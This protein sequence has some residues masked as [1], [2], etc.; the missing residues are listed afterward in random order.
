LTIEGAT[1]EIDFVGGGLDSG[2]IRVVGNIGSFAARL[3]TGGKIE[4]R[5]NVGDYL[6]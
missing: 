2:T 5:G 1:S 6:A 3:M 4:V